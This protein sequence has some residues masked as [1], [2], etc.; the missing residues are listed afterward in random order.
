MATNVFDLV[1]LVDLDPTDIRMIEYN[2]KTKGAKEEYSS[3]LHDLDCSKGY[4]QTIDYTYKHKV[5]KI[6][7]IIEHYIED[8]SFKQVLIETLFKQHQDNL[9]YE[10]N[11]PP[12]IYKT[13]TRTKKDKKPREYKEKVNKIK[14]KFKDVKFVLK[15]N[16]V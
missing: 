6:I 16:A 7:Y 3:L 12:V 9:E 1:E 8:L 5:S 2:V 13:K 14:N 10:S 4:I 15:L 11:N